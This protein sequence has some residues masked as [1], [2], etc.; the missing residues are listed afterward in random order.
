M[1]GIGERLRRV[2]SYGL[3]GEATLTAYRAAHRGASAGD[4]L[5]AIQTE[6]WMRFDAI[7][8]VVDDPRS[9][10]RALWDGLR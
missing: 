5:A 10:E 3:P 9:A 8:Q 1:H 4:L 6:W 2:A 7:S